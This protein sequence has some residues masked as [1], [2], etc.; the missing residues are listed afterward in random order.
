MRPAT[1]LLVLLLPLLAPGPALSGAAGG[2]AAEA[3]SGDLTGVE[4]HRHAGASGGA[5]VRNF[6]EAGD[7][8]VFPDAA[9]GPWL[10]VRYSLAT[11]PEARLTVRRGGASATENSRWRPRSTSAG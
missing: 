2:F 8:V 9:G 7:A 3:E 10:R 6:D 4:V 1:V 11:G 5:R